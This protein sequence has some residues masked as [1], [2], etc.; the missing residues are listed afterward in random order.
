[1]HISKDAL[2]KGI[3]ENLI[4]DFIRY[5]FPALVDEIDFA[6]GFEFLDT[7]L[8]K[9][10]PNNPAH[11]RHADKLIKAW[12]K[13][14]QEVGLL[15]GAEVWFLIHIEVQGYQDPYFAQR[16]FECMYRIRD[17]YQ[18][19]VTGLAIYTDWDR[20]YHYTEFQESF[21]GSVVNYR[22][23]TYVLRDHPV[24]EL[25][26]DPNPFAA[27][28]EAAWQNLDKPQDD[29]SLRE[30]KIDLIQRLKSRNIAR[31]KISLIID[32]IRFFL[33][34][35]D[36]EI[37]A[38]FEQDLIT[39][40]NLNIPM[41]LREAILEDVKKQG[42]EQGIVKGIEQGIELEKQEFTLKLWALQ[43]FSIEKIAILVDLPHERVIEII[44]EFLKL[45]GQSESI[46]MQTIEM[47]QSRFEGV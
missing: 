37:S 5:F 12:F 42:I 30:L 4:D 8:Q 21:G 29:Q 41:G 7:E 13:D 14:E 26:Q 9:L 32:F 40:N 17:K 45:E 19:P 36:S 27:V 28:M 46:A 1:M 35:T 23:N 10:I 31:E 16:M 47:Y 22:F 15:S 24:V 6:R 18:H 43:E 3:I 33:P 39:I 2:W 34:F 25:A 44:A 20:T 11:N 38:N